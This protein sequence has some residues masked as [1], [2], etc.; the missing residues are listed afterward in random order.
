MPPK[1][2]EVDVDEAQRAL[3]EALRNP[4]QAP[5]SAGQ[6]VAWIVSVFYLLISL[7][8]GLVREVSAQITDVE[9]DFNSRIP[10]PVT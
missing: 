10:A 2:A 5:A 6:I 4:I 3:K 9:S 7:M 1:I 8:E